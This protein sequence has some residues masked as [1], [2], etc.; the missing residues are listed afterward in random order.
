M[1]SG[2][3]RSGSTL[4]CQLLNM[5]PEF[6][7]TPTS[8][9]LDMLLAQQSC[10]SHNPGFKATDRMSTYDNFK[11]AQKAFL[12][13]YC[14]TN[15]KVTFDKNRGWPSHLQ[16]LDHILDNSSSKIIWTYRD[17]VHICC[18]VEEKHKQ[19]ALIQFTEEAQGLGFDTLGGRVNSLISD[20]GIIG[21]PGWLLND[22]VEMGYDKRIMIVGYGELCTNTQ[23]VMDEIHDFLGLPRYDYAK[24]NFADLKQTTK[25]FDTFYNYKYPH[26]IKE[27]SI[28]Y[29]T[30]TITLPQNHIDAINGRFTWVNDY[31]RKSISTRQAMRKIA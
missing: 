10:Y 7:A 24:N 12:E 28:S 17:P 5:N 8:P 22:A 30:P 15:K 11:K 18:S 13:T 21:R 16:M 26:N 31:A 29:K 25:E 23:T 6:N 4:L 27:G 2:F 19:T 1:V 3:P 9:L 20:N 14:D